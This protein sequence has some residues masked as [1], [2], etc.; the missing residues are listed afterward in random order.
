MCHSITVQSQTYRFLKPQCQ[1]DRDNTVTGTLL[2]CQSILIGDLQVSK[3]TCVKGGR[4]QIS[5]HNSKAYPGASKHKD[6]HM[7]T[8][9]DM[10]AH[11]FK[12]IKFESSNMQIIE[13]GVSLLS[14]MNITTQKSLLISFKKL[15][16]TL[17]FQ[18]C[19]HSAWH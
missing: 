12:N 18:K 1:G 9:E 11:T 14:N 7:C 13:F 2:T 6:V 17:P 4:W 5:E 10:P 15:I 16:T 3:R 19:T 8:C